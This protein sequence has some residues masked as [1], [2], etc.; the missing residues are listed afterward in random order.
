MCVF[1]AKHKIFNLDVGDFPTNQIFFGALT[2]V[3]R[4]LCAKTVPERLPIVPQKTFNL[5]LDIPRSHS[6]IKYLKKKKE[7]TLI[8]FEVNTIP[9]KLIPLSADRTASR[10]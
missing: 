3:V 5:T 10:I 9:V 6:N 1:W 8:I 4:K 7:N 2:A